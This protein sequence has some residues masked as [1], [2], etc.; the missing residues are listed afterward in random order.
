MTAAIHISEN[1]FVTV[2]EKNKKC[3]VKLA[4]TG[5]GRCNVT[6]IAS[7]REMLPMIPRGGKFLLSALNG[8]SSAD[9]ME[10]F[11]SLG[12]PL[13]TERGGRVFPVSDKAGDIVSALNGEIKRRKNIRVEFSAV[14]SIEKA[15]E[16]FTVKTAKGEF[17]F[18]KVIIATGGKSYP[19]TGSDGDGYRFAE[20]LG[21]TVSPVRPALVP[22]NTK[23]KFVSSLSGLSLKNTAITVTDRNG[24]K[25]YSDF[26]EMLFCHFGVSGPMILSASSY[27]DFSKEPEYRLFIDLKPALDR[28]TLDRRIL[29]DFSENLNRNFSN[30]LSRLLPSSLIPVIVALSGTDPEKKVNLITRE[31]RRTL[32]SLLKAL[33]LT[34]TSPRPMDEAIITCGGVSTGEIN[35]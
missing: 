17:F 5:K 34:L 24:K 11:T 4:I 2:F 7:V 19:S 14:L 23:E 25:I 9:V 32:V 13:K 6:N 20:A 18:D 22:I 3:G 12:V 16:G 15:S 33:P 27:L 26:G 21:H 35:P 8:F 30:S 28:E 31:E 29:S 1:C 10:F